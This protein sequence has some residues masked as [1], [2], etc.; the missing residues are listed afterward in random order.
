MT[1]GDLV[2][3]ALGSALMLPTPLYLIA[4]LNSDFDYNRD[5]SLTIVCLI[6][7]LVG[8][9]LIGHGALRSQTK[10]VNGKRTLTRSLRSAGSSTCSSCDRSS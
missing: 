2:F 7:A 1:F 4:V 3:F 5:K 6:L 9:F 10:Y 8:M